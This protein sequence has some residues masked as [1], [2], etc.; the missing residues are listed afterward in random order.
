[1][2][3]FKKIIKQQSD[4][5]LIFIALLMLLIAWI[6]PRFINLIPGIISMAVIVILFGR[7]I[8]NELD[9]R[10]SQSARPWWM[11]Y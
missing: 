1:M 2:N 3:Q 10:G 8:N 5:G 9:K 4:A 6:S 11:Q 7:A